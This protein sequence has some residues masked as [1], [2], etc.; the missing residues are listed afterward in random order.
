MLD[1][2]LWETLEKMGEASERIRHFLKKSEKVKQLE[3]KKAF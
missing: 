3:K 1:V 2:E